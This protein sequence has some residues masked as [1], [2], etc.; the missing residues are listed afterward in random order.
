MNK[1]KKVEIEN[2]EQTI[3]V[4]PYKTT[5]DKELNPLRIRVNKKPSLLSLFS[6]CCFVLFLFFFGA[7]LFYFVSLEMGHNG[8]HVARVW[9]AGE[10]QTVLFFE[11][12][13]SLRPSPLFLLLLLVLS[14]SFLF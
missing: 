4:G 5:R 10:R 11:T 6:L 13:I 1:R 3:D 9:L 2:K 14:F 7:T 12:L 8:A